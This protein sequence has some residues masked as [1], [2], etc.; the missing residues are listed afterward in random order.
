[1]RGMLAG[2]ILI[3]VGLLEVPLFAADKKG[4]ASCQ[5]NLRLS[6]ELAKE[7]YDKRDQAEREKVAYK[8]AFESEQR[9][10]KSLETQ[11]ADLK[12]KLES[13]ADEKK[14]E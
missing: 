5:D 12:K 4:E 13:K 8:S 2:L 6:N 9:A 10:R 7:Y 1:M 3:A 14:P 11:I